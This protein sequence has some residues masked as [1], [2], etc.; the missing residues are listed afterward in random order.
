LDSQPSSRN[1][2]NPPY[3]MIGGSRKRRQ[4][5]EAR[6]APRSYP[7]VAVISQGEIPQCSSPALY[8]IVADGRIRWASAL[9]SSTLIAELD[10]PPFIR[11]GRAI[12]IEAMPQTAVTYTPTQLRHA[13]GLDQVNANGQGQT[14][15]IIDGVP[16]ING[17][18]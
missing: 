17:V 1:W 10:R 14:I 12:Q 13:Y 15:A 3:G 5:F 9:R 11:V 18:K 2:G 6:T 8:V 16:F 7:T 4:S